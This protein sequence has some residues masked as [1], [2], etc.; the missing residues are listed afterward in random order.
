[1]IRCVVFNYGA[2]V[3]GFAGRHRRRRLRRG[4]VAPRG[5]RPPTGRGCQDWRTNSILTWHQSRYINLRPDPWVLKLN[6]VCLLR[7]SGSLSVARVLIAALCAHDA[8]GDGDGDGVGARVGVPI[9]SYN[10]FIT[11][12]QHNCY[13]PLNTLFIGVRNLRL[14]LCHCRHVQVEKKF[15]CIVGRLYTYTKILFWWR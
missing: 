12:S 2:L 13:D 9:N 14:C 5:S 8:H 10:N 1:M 15:D 4:R 11:A 3:S 6:I 7:R